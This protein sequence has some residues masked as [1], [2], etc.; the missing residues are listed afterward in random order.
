MIQKNSGLE[1]ANVEPVESDIFVEKVSGINE[2]FIRGADV[3]SIIALENSG[4]EFYDWDGN[5][6]DIFQTLAESGVNYIRIRVW[7]DPFDDNGIG[8]GSGNNDVATAIEIGKRAT[9]HGMRVL[10]NFHYSDFWEN[11]EKQQAPR[12]WE[13]KHY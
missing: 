3:S 12:A 11:P 10:V 13:P 2:D 6:Q 7:N 9:D 5:E 1:S 8:F 4:V